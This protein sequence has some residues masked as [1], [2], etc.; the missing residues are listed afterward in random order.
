MALE[1][2]RR[3][4]QR[5]TKRLSTQRVRTLP[6]VAAGPAVVRPAVRH[7]LSHERTAGRAGH[8]NR[9]DAIPECAQAGAHSV[10]S[11]GF[12]SVPV[13]QNGADAFHLSG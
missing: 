3:H 5:S 8:V 13:A 9:H 7:V 11:E 1:Q 12:A 10:K 6:S 4:A 2:G